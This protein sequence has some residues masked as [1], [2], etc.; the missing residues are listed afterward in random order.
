[1][2]WIPLHLYSQYTILGSTISIEALTQ[3]A[4]SL[5]IGHL[6][7]TDQGNLY[8]AVEFF[9]GC[10][11]VKIHPV[12]GCEIVLAPKSRLDKK[13]I[14]GVKPGASI[15]L[16]AKNAHGFHNLS[17]LSSLGFLEGFYYT[18]RIDKELLEQHHEGLICL[19]GS[20]FSPFG[21]LICAGQEAALEKEVQWYQSLFK[22]DFYFEL[23]R[24]KMEEGKLE[25]EGMK[26]ESFL[27]Q[28]YQTYVQEQ[29][30][31]NSTFL[32]LSKKYG[33]S[34]VATNKSCY[35]ERGDW[36]AH[37]ILLNIQS[38]EPCEMVEKD[39]F[40]RIKGRTLNPKRSVLSSH[41]FYFKTPAEMQLLF[42]DVPEA[43]ENTIKVAEKCDFEFDFKKKYYPVFVPP[44][45]EGTDFT[46]EER[47]KAAEVFLKKLCL[48]GI[49]QRYTPEALAA[50][51]AKYPG[52][53][54]LTVIH[55]RL[56]YELSVILPKGMG[57]Y[58]LIVWDFIAWAK[59]QK[60]PMGPGRGS[61]AGSIVLYLIGITDIEPLRFNL[62]FERFIN[63][64]RISYP[65]IDVDICMDR[66]A[67]VIDYTVKK[68][69][70]D[71]VAQI[72]TF[73]TMKAKMAIKDVGRVLNIP[74]P[75]VT[76]IA[77]LIPEDPQMT[78]AKAFEIDPEL[79]NLYD[80][81][82]E[83][84]KLIDLARILEGSVRNTGIHAAGIIIS[85]DP[86][87]DRIPVCVAKDSEMAVTQFS[88]KPVESVGMLKIDFLGLKTLTAIQHAVD[89]LDEKINWVGLPLNDQPTFDLLSQGKTLGIFQLESSGM[90]DLVKQ[91][92]VD[93][94]EEIVAINALYRPGP[95]EMIPSFIQRKKGQE[96]I[97]FEHEWMKDILSETYGI[98][99]YQEQVM[100]IASRLAG[101]T[102]GEGDVLRRAMGKKDKEEMAKQ[103]EKFQKGAESKGIDG[104]LAVRIFD[105]VEKFAAYGFNKSHAAAYGYLSYVTA[106]LKAHYPAHWMAALMTADFDDLSKVARMI[107]EC[108]AMGIPVLPPD[109]NTSGRTF[110]ATREG[111][112]FS[113]AGIK[114]VGEGVV[115]TILEERKKNGPFTSLYDL[116]SRLDIRKVGKKTLENLIESGALD[117]LQWSRAACLAS[118]DSMVALA[119]KKQKEKTLG[120]MDFLS[121]LDQ[122]TTCLKP[123]ENIEAISR[124]KQL[125]REYELLGFYL[126]GH[127]LDDFQEHLRRLSCVPFKEL[128]NIPKGG[129]FRIGFIIE[130]LQLRIS[131]KTQKKFAIL[132]ISDGVERLELPIW[133]DL[134]EQ[135][136]EVLV[137]NH[138]LFGVVQVE[139]QAG[140][141]RFQCRYLAD[142]SILDEEMIRTCDEA[143]DKAKEQARIYEIREK[144]MEFKKSVEAQASAVENALKLQCDIEKL[145]M[146]HIL[147]LKDLFRSFPG[148]S[149]VTL[150]FY[151][152]TT[153]ISSLEI[154]ATWG[155]SIDAQLLEGV[156]KVSSVRT[157]SSSME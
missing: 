119:S 136:A 2:S 129:V 130:G 147:Q 11:A 135:K 93:T 109:I 13:K 137:E 21:D 40:G 17:R 37:E 59:R 114:G 36:K 146:S 5:G 42:S 66:R 80:S 56:E 7:L 52:K 91:M 55:E 35:L 39:S 10:K 78:L 151:H 88:M 111:I 74:L 101:Y 57:D 65:D 96:P 70:K 51:A 50:V 24:H 124:Q 87:L 153:L 33:I 84:K 75:R 115:D 73:G 81:D 141:R 107:R 133:P 1:M 148:K 29:E 122:D 128:D 92:H 121:H 125:K 54:P 48:E 105:K 3:K 90:Q 9:K 76:E 149:P 69:G 97:D 38:G 116:V 45:I 144:K 62:F 142:L 6:A 94:F 85:A 30:K 138:L 60:I 79:Q 4:A 113:L 100:Q 43:L 31:I 145:R 8:G 104:N 127:P 106:Y 134:Y 28:Q 18:P 27:Y 49:S 89:A 46:K 102:L 152:G 95:M 143:Y 82:P 139:S 58:L 83:V 117:S 53:D 20:L 156:R 157:A 72:I 19:S 132:Q 34:C 140:E 44:E 103:R 126:N 61:G 41:E 14:P 123:P 155:V 25:E 47:L 112:R 16:L 77:K 67:E 154:D 64:E 68:Y 150:A 98:M 86:I 71:K 15:V 32:N 118:L 99:V 108:Q 63:P 26:D 131:S 12:I 110:V 22:E 120:V 23:M